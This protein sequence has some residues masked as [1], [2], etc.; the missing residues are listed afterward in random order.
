MLL[1][2]PV[3]CVN[4][5]P[6]S[7]ELRHCR[8]R[9]ARTRS[10]RMRHTPS[11]MRSSNAAKRRGW[12]TTTGLDKVQCYLVRL[13]VGQVAW[14]MKVTNRKECGGWPGPMA[15]QFA[16]RPNKATLIPVSDVV[17]AST[18]TRWLSAQASRVGCFQAW[19]TLKMTVHNGVVNIIRA[20][21]VVSSPVSLGQWWPEGFGTGREQESTSVSPDMLP[22][23]PHEMAK[24]RARQ[25]C[26]LRSE[27][28]WYYFL[29]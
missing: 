9:R 17:W 20:I 2:R 21:C 13:A 27:W 3:V 8:G 10:R 12:T 16:G 26:R 19:P 4:E 22:T 23:P 15:L 24:S 11:G 18:P 28:P 6:V 1:E 25:H 14:V 5:N 29:W 7:A